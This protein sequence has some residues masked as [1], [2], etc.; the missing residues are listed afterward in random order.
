M[1]ERVIPPRS[2]R[3][4]APTAS[5]RGSSLHWRRVPAAARLQAT[6]QSTACAFAGLV[7]P[8]AILGHDARVEFKGY[9]GTIEVDGELLSI[10]HSGLVAK[11]GG[12]VRDQPRRIPLQAVSGVRF[13]EATRLANGHL[14]LGL[15]GADPV[16]VGSQAASNPDTVMFRH[17]DNEQFQRLQQWLLAV[18]ETNRKAGID[19]SAVEFDPAGKTRIERGSR[20]RAS[21]AQRRLSRSSTNVVSSA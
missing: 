20:R 11:A 17:R 7:A 12:L 6:P 14:T 13:K 8:G 19:S 3:P 5:A 2:A 21:S 9:N 10:T 1:C 18:V 15:A 4:S 16:D